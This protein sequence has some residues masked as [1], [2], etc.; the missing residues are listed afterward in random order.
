MRGE[1]EAAILNMLHGAGPRSGEARPDGF[2]RQCRIGFASLVC[3]APPYAADIRDE[4]GR[5]PTDAILSL[6][7]PVWCWISRRSIERPLSLFF[8]LMSAFGRCRNARAITSGLSSRDT[9]KSVAKSTPPT[10]GLAASLNSLLTDS[11]P[12]P[13]RSGPSRA[14]RFHGVVRSAR[15]VF[16][17]RRPA[18]VRTFR[19]FLPTIFA[20][21]AAARCAE[22]V[23][24]FRQPNLRKRCE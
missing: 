5:M 13:R 20:M 24:I 14:P 8:R 17:S 10:P 9:G 19:R 15:L 22:L 12:G 1:I 4:I 2:L 23:Q 6:G 16:C 18:G 11:Q 21:S 7:Y 3:P